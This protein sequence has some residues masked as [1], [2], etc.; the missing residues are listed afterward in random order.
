MG[1]FYG[2][3][4]F[5][6]KPLDKVAAE[7]MYTDDNI[8][9]L[10]GKETELKE[11][12][13]DIYSNM[14]SCRHQAD[15]RPSLEYAKDLVAS[16]LIEDY[17]STILQ[18]HYYSLE[19]SGADRNRKILPSAR[20]SASSDYLIRTNDISIKLEL[21]ND[22][23][24][25]W[26]KTH[27]L[28]LRDNKY[29]QLKKSGSLFIAIATPS[30]EF[31]LYDFRETIPA[32]YIP[33]HRSYGGKPVYELDIPSSMLIPITKTSMKQEIIKHL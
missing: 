32:R 8:L 29:I 7:L 4:R 33:E 10:S 1:A 18:S 26:R 5:F 30:S 13:P 22:Y 19:L 21:M 6:G 14:M 12:Y 24:G 23:T 3:S 28:H 15:G 27:K 31:A 2:V 25:F 9:I 20:T 16:W 17:F 11:R